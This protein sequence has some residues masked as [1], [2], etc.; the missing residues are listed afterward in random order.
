MENWYSF[1]ER[2]Q[3]LML[4]R[5]LRNLLD[6]VFRAGIASGEIEEEPDY[7]LKFNPLWS[8]S[9]AEQATVNLAKAQ[10]AL[11]KAQATQVYVEMQALDPSEVRTALAA[12][13]EYNVEDVIAEDDDDDLLEALM[14]SQPDAVNELEAAQKSAEELKTPGGGEQSAGQASP[15]QAPLFQSGDFDSYSRDADAT[16]TGV[17]VLVVV[18]TDVFND[19]VKEMA[20]N[21]AMQAAALKPQ[22]THRDEVSA[23][24]IEKEKEIMTV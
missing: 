20:K 24:Y 23:D 14:G 2:I 5:N 7:K 1:V 11:A 12:D 9:G 21:V 3:K 6:V 22:F 13:G 4:K 8:L 16:P 19:A 15:A 17:G 18:E 10:T